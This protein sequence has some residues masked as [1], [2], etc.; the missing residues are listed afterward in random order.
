VSRA[1][2]RAV[3]APAAAARA[4][5]KTS[6]AKVQPALAANNRSRRNGAAPNGTSRASQAVRAEVAERKRRARTGDSARAVAA[7]LGAGADLGTAVRA[8]SVKRTAAKRAP[9]RRK[10]RAG[11]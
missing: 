5:G 1:K 10:G 9:T 3:K 6:A 11:K 8:G 7:A 4:K 2:R